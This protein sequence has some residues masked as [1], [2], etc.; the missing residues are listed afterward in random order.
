MPRLLL[1][2]HQELF[3]KLKLD[4]DQAAKEKQDAFQSKH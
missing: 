1:F 3:A 2:H 4:F